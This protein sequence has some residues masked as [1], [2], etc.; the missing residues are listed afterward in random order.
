MRLTDWLTENKVSRSD[1][2]HLTFT[3]IAAVN[4]WCVGRRVPA[5]ANVDAIHQLTNGQVTEIDFRQAYAE[6]QRRQ[7][8]TAV[9][10]KPT[11]GYPV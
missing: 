4:H 3:T 8:A 9:P 5:A 2:A 6:F 7:K 1:F 10:V 11:Q